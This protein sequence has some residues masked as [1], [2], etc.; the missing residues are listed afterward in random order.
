M[1]DPRLTFESYVVGPSNRLAA[2]A[3][4]R[5]A[6][7]PGQAYN[8][9]FVHAP[10]GLGKTHL[11]MAIGN[12]AV[13]SGSDVHVMY[14]TLERLMES[15]MAAIEA[16]ERDAFRTRVRESGML[17]LDDVQFLAGRH[18]LQEELL[19]AWDAFLVQ[20]GQ[21]VLAS[22]RPP[23]EI[24]GL[25]Q[26][27]LTRFSGGL[28][29]DL[30]P[31]DYETRVAIVRR[32]SEERGQSLSPGVAEVLARAALENV[33]ELQGRLNRVL[34]GQELDGRPLS[35]EEVAKL[36]G[37]PVPPDDS[38][39]FREFLAEIAG[40]VDELV[41]KLDAGIEPM[42]G[43]EEFPAPPPGPALDDLPLDPGSFAV[44]AA[45]TVPDEPGERY[46]PFV[47]YGGRDSGKTALLLAIAHALRER[48]PEMRVAYIE[49]RDFTA[50]LIEAIEQGRLDAW[51]ARW[52]SAGALLIDDVDALT[53]TERAQEELFHL[54]DAL[55][56]RN[57]QLV[58]SAS[59]PPRELEG[60]EARLRTR[61][62]SGL[63]VDL[64]E[65]QRKPVQ[66][67]GEPVDEWFLNPEKV[68][69]TWPYLEAWLEE[70]AR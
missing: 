7:A 41:E 16:G 47:A 35:A 51:R 14:D 60:M 31:P 32:K 38:P 30:G 22:D 69:W 56:A 65:A 26:R 37:V 5:V 40:T 43:V 58:F 33:R 67:T 15:V 18:A 70:D 45:R 6:E 49:G 23:A 2:A 57:A 25:D 10:S 24:D 21:V 62:E 48:H 46:S 9:L 12:H 59:A 1:L 68:L 64:N 52:R 39:E 61:L 50:G 11:L 63:V 8:P 28:I 34:A 55:R 53:A 66:Q 17:L 42:A 27:L 20:G 4:R 44:R 36:L 54:F 19:R 13:R 3:A 29:A